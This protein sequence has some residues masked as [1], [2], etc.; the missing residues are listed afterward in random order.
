MATLWPAIRREIETPLEKLKE[1]ENKYRTLKEKYDKVVEENKSSMPKL[2]KRQQKQNNLMS[3][4]L[5]VTP[6]M[7]NILQNQ[8]P[9]DLEKHLH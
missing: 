5:L 1:L 3:W 2:S 4:T 7:K 8:R 9:R 6:Q